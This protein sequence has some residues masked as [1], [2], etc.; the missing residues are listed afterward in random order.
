MEEIE[1]A[2]GALNRRSSYQPP[3]KR[4]YR[5]LSK[6]GSRRKTCPEIFSNDND[7]NEDEKVSEFNFS[8]SLRVS[9]TDLHRNF[10]C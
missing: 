8:G 3:Q 6:K 4:K 9:I 10:P 2:H 1:K 5:I 7:S